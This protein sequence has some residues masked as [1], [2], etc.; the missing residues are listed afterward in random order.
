MFTETLINIYNSQ[1]TEMPKYPATDEEIKKMLHIYIYNGKYSA[2]KNN[3]V[4]P[5]AATWTALNHRTK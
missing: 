1:D 5:F 4:M 2:M 3:E